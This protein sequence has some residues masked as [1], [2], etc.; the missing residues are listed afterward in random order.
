MAQSIPTNAATAMAAEAARLKRIRLIV[1]T[2][3]RRFKGH[4]ERL[5]A[6]LAD[7]YALTLDLVESN[8]LISFVED[9]KA[10]W[11]KVARGNPFH[12]IVALAFKDSAGAASASRYAAVLHYARENNVSRA[13]IKTWLSEGIEKLLER[14]R[15]SSTY[16]I[17]EETPEERMDRALKVL[18][19]PIGTAQP[20]AATAIPAI[21]GPAPDDA[22]ADFRKALV[23]VVGG[24]LEV[25]KI[26]PSSAA[27][28]TQE[29]LAVAPKDPK[30]GKRKLS[31]KPYYDIFRACELMTRFAS[32]ASQPDEQE[33]SAYVVPSS[34]AIDMEAWKRSIEQRK[35]PKPSPT[36]SLRIAFHED[37]WW[38]ETVST[39][40]T[41]PI[42]RMKLQSDLSQM[43][44]SKTYV[45]SWHQAKRVVTGFVRNAEWTL[46]VRQVLSSG[47]D[48]AGDTEIVLDE[49]DTKLAWHQLTELTTTSTS[50]TLQPDTLVLILNWAAEFK[51]NTG[52]VL[53][54]LLA[55]DV[56][57]STL[58]VRPAGTKD[59]ATRLALAAIAADATPSSTLSTRWLR[60][61]DLLELAQIH[62]DYGKPMAVKLMD[63]N[64]DLAAL[65]LEH[66]DATIY[67]PLTVSLAGD[68]AEIAEPA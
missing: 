40:P 26:L 28:L 65:Q 44:T 36:T 64:E 63:G 50:F 62:R 39:R 16:D 22:I 35:K 7:A 9:Q 13:D 3:E 49:F 46:R 48:I 66:G 19:T 33:Q 34:G 10:K 8:L 67:V 38:A 11:G 15:G 23:R 51:G 24:Q 60:R 61:D 25:V 57:N 55:L 41:F 54:D 30:L 2:S 58:S 20:V 29:V 37:A 42:V 68:Y 1:E 18:S 5:Y 14:A 43:D 17:Y 4:Q 56:T 6:A 59:F 52:K 12:P 47:H 21:T 45:I 27:E 32:V 31:A 53:P